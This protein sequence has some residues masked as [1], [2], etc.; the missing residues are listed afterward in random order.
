M[1]EG[2]GPLPRKNNFRPQNDKFGCILPQFVTSGV[3]AC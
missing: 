2:A 3:G 1:V